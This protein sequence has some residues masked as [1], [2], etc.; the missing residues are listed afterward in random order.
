M[1]STVNGVRGGLTD[2]R[3]PNRLFCSCGVCRTTGGCVGRQGTLF[4]MGLV[5]LFYACTWWGTLQGL[6]KLIRYGTARPPPPP[7]PPE[8]VA[9]AGTTKKIA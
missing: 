1:P 2:P 6:A 9:E 8:G 3:R 5:E 7:P 4:A